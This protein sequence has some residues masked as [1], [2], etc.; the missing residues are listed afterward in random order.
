MCRGKERHGEFRWGMWTG[1]LPVA[2][3]LWAHSASAPPGNWAHS[4]GRRAQPTPR[5]PSFLALQLC[6]SC[7]RV[8]QTVP[9]PGLPKHFS[10][11]LVTPLHRELSRDTAIPWPMMLLALECP[12][13]S[14]HTISCLLAKFLPHGSLGNQWRDDGS[15]SQS[16]DATPLQ[17]G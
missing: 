13:P 2:C 12:T 5:L 1:G 7:P 14:L 8:G 15:C 4:V 16:L 6:S 9:C 11:C 3:D 10:G 17:T